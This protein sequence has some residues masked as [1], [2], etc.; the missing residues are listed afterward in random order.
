MMIT[1][2]PG[3]SPPKGPF[4]AE[5]ALDVVTIADE[6]FHACAADLTRLRR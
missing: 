3:D 2:D 1:F 5:T 6:L 4:E